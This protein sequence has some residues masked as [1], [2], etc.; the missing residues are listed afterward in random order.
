MNWLRS[1]SLTLALAGLAPGLTNAQPPSAIPLGLPTVFGQ[2]RPVAVQPPPAAYKIGPEIAPLPWSLPNSAW[3]APAPTPVDEGRLIAQIAEWIRAWARNSAAQAPTD[4]QAVVVTES[5][6]PEPS[7]PLAGKCCCVSMLP[8]FLH[9]WLTN[10]PCCLRPYAAIGRAVLGMACAQNEEDLIRNIPS[11]AS[12]ENPPTSNPVA[13]PAMPHDA[14]CTR[15]RY[16]RPGLEVEFTLRAPRVAQP[17]QTSAVAQPDMPTGCGVGQATTPA[18][19]GGRAPL[20]VPACPPEFQC[21][22]QIIEAACGAKSGG[23]ATSKCAGS[24]A[25]CAVAKDCCCKSKCACVKTACACPEDGCV[26]AEKKCGCGKDC[27]CC[28]CKKSASLEEVLDDIRCCLRALRAEQEGACMPPP[29]AM[30]CPPLPE[31]PHLGVLPPPPPRPSSFRSRRPPRHAGRPRR[32]LP[33]PPPMPAIERVAVSTVTVATPSA[34]VKIETPVFMAQCDSITCTGH[35]DEVVLEGH[36][37]VTLK[38][39][40]HPCQVSAERVVVN[41]KTGAFRAASAATP[42]TGPAV[43]E[44]YP[45]PSYAPSPPPVPVWRMESR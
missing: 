26:C 9:D 25:P 15:Y 43:Y 21:I 38:R 22:G 11:P 12:P 44:S 3:T 33:T 34:A 32:L 39:G 30:P 41:T 40:A 29:I 19:T 36:V 14:G 31:A 42:V 10:C 16:A 8:A 27:G 2:D 7:C 4:V 17:V 45:A 1:L 13:T 6:L 23:C 24:H 35:P 37:R 20:L 18:W 28:A 5:V